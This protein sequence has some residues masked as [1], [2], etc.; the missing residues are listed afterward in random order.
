MITQLPGIRPEIAQQAIPEDERVWVPQAPDVWFRPLLLN[1]VTGSWCNLLRVRKSGVLSR[2][3]HPSWVTGLVL[4]GSWRYL[5]HDWIAHEGAFVYEPPGEIHT[6]VVDQASGGAQE[7]ITFFNIHGAMVYVDEQGQVT[8]Y[9][10]V[11][12]KIEMCRKHYEACGLG[13]AL[14]DQYVR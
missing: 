13:G 11:F 10:D 3:I 9:E 2:H 8:G 7:M 1:T 12:T 4:K 14:V 5:E 6:L